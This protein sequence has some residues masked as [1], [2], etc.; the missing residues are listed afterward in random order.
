M[1]WLSLCLGPGNNIH[2][3][4]YLGRNGEY[5]SED[6]VL[7]YYQTK[8]EV[9]GAYKFGLSMGPKHFAFNDQETNRSGVSTFVNEQAAREIY[10][11]AFEGAL[12]SG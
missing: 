7:S 12:A 6:G 9:S 1:D 3:T 4:A 10:L 2:R 11:R 5:Y 8:N